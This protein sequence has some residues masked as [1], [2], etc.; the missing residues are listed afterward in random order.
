MK[1]KNR[2]ELEKTLCRGYRVMIV[3][4]SLFV[5]LILLTIIKN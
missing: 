1:T 3:I 2:T 5:L 4:L